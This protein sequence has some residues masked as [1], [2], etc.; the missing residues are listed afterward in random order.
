MSPETRDGRPVEE[1]G[2]PD[3]TCNPEHATVHRQSRGEWFL[4]SQRRR[5]LAS[6]RMVPLC[7]G[8]RD[9]ERADGSLR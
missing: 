2:H 4:E 7:S 1:G 6:K 9:P 8:H 3:A 5:H